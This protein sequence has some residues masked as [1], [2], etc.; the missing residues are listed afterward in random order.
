MF[1][2]SVVGVPFLNEYFLYQEDVY[3]SWRLRLAGEGV[4]MA[5]GSLVRH[6]G[7]ATAGRRPTPLTTFYQERNRMLNC[8]LFY[9]GGTL[10]R[11]LPYFIADGAGKILLSVAGRGKSLKG[12][13]R[14]YGWLIGNRRWIGNERRHMQ[15]G[16]KVADSGILE[17]MSSKV[18]DSDTAPARLLNALSRLY[19][20]IVGLRYH[21]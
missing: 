21:A 12:I 18:V 10:V 8:L 9:E 1:R 2:K 3:L 11:L 14:A 20:N 13:L 5:Q 15:A 7:S 16:R 4:G 6:L 17:L 19:A